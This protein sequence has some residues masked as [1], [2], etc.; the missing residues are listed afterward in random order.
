[1]REHRWFCQIRSSN[2]TLGHLT[3]LSE[4][5]PDGTNLRSTNHRS[6]LTTPAMILLCEHPALHRGMRERPINSSV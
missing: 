1:M 5:V 3:S 2:K 6:D 4:S